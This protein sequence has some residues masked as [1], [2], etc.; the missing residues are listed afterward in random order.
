MHRTQ[1]MLEESQYHA[2]R[3]K[4]RSDGKSIGQLIREFVELGLKS[5]SS[6][7]KK[8]RRS[9]KQLQGLFSEPDTSGRDHDRHLYG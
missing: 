6:R 8:R 4:A 5:I 7:P 9:L 2:L 1:I 3:E